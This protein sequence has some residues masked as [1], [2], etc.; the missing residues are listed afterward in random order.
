MQDYRININYAKALFLLAG[1]MDQQEAV[2]QDM[3]LIESVCTENRV[4]NVVFNNPT[5]K[6]S[7]KVAILHE[8][9][10]QKVCPLT[11]TFLAFVVKKRRTVNLR[12]ISRSYLDLYRDREGIVL[13]SL[14]TAEEADDTLKAMVSEVIAQYT[15]RKVELLTK[16]KPEALGGFAMLFDNKMLDARISTRMDK[17]YREFA[18]NDYESKL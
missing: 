14:T 10:A 15:G 2:S 9:F 8:L 1:E 13:S 5:I 12:G 17:L 3:R 7:K 4:L 18:R 6:E 16:T 11:V